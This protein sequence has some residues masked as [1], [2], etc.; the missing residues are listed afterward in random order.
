MQLLILGRGAP[1]I[2]ARRLKSAGS[3][4]VLGAAMCSSCEFIS[5]RL[6][7]FVAA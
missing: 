6:G 3:L 7:P 5:G 4:A 1:D 2:L